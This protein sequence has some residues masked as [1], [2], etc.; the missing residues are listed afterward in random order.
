[1]DREKNIREDRRYRRQE[2]NTLLALILITIGLIFL[3][4]NF[5]ILPWSIWN[6]LWRFWPLILI[7]IGLQI[8]F[9]RNLAGRLLVALISLVLVAFILAFTIAQVDPQFNHWL[10]SQFPWWRWEVITNLEF[11]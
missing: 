11:R 8:I 6:L 4:N 9:G 5:G 10:Q 1:M 7:L 3:L 2:S